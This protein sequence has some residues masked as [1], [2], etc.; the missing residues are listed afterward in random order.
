MRGGARGKGREEERWEGEEG[1]K[2]RGVRQESKG[3]E[4]FTEFLKIS[5]TA[6]F[7]L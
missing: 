3:F 2:G 1:G 6:T 5:H 7:V 4:E